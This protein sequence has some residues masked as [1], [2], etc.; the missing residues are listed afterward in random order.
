MLLTPR[1]G[2]NPVLH[3]EGDPAAIGELFVRQRRRLVTLLTELSSEQ[4]AQP[5]RCDGWSV[6]DVAV[7]LSSTNW[8]WEASIRAGL[9][10]EPTTVMAG[11][12]PVASPAE[13]VEAS[14][15][16]PD[17]IVQNLT[18]T[19]ESIAACFAEMKPADWTK[20]AES[21]P[22]HVTVSAVAHHGFWDAWIHERDVLLPLGEV[23]TEAPD[24]VMA[25][26]RY[27]AS[28]SP[29][30]VLNSGVTQAGSFGVA[31]TDID[32]SFHVEIGS[33]VTVRDGLGAS[34][35]VLSG[36]AVELVETLSFRASLDLG[37]P[38]DLAWAFT[39]ISDV[40]DR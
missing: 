11:F 25:S 1:H 3:L 4:W 19:G 30:V 14:S 18:E 12:D 38:D 28:L 24:E 34:E 37:I 15:M 5:S 32:E 23:P 35:F 17:E 29:A 9:A 31:P 26:L 22:G 10:G 16:S 13:M 2:S 7:H 6:Q 20:L 33:D 39:G 27:V 8:F 21:P 36:N 40:F